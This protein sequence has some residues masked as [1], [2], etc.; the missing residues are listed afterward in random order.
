MNQYEAGMIAQLCSQ[1]RCFPEALKKGWK[2][3]SM[4]ETDEIR[5]VKRSGST[6]LQQRFYVL[7]DLPKPEF[8]NQDS[9]NER[10]VDM[11]LDVPVIEEE[12]C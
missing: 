6:V 2:M 4:N 8:Y 10:T 12:E 11:W 1:A 9:V 5:W 7:F 3:R